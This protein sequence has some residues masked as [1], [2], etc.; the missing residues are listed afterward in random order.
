MQRTL[1]LL[2]AAALMLA[3]SAQAHVQRATGSKKH[4]LQVRIAHDRGVVAAVDREAR[5]SG[6][7]LFIE[8]HEWLTRQWHARD[9][10]AARAALQRMTLPAHYAGWNCI[11]NGAYPG[12]PHEG[13][14][15]NGPYSGWL[16]M[17]N[18][19]LGQSGNWNAMGAA[20]YAVAERV[21]A[22]QGFSPAFMRG[23][24]PNT[25]PPC[26]RFF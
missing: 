9:L 10:A 4:Q 7:A 5:S 13:S 2:C 14:G 3:A 12:A 8:W 17:T 24:W 26:A 19:W 15:T 23:Q 16:Q 20:V 6:S 1:V 22:R 25:Y 18:P 21:A 11:H